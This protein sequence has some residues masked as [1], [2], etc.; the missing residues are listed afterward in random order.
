MASV[1]GQRAPAPFA[2]TGGPLT[3]PESPRDLC[4]YYSPRGAHAGSCS[5]PAGPAK[6]RSGACEDTG[7]A[8]RGEPHQGSARPR[9]PNRLPSHPPPPLD[10][11]P[12]TLGHIWDRRLLPSRLSVLSGSSRCHDGPGGSFP[13]QGSRRLPGSGTSRSTPSSQA[14]APPPTHA[15]ASCQQLPG[16]GFG[17]AHT[18][19]CHWVWGDVRLCSPAH[20][21]LPAPPPPRAPTPRLGDRATHGSE[22]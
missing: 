19:P 5:G 8:A 3:C 22:S 11:V 18:A 10:A 2:W 17:A 7:D 20:L 4:R 21:P 13:F 12:P 1:T 16:G 15:C 6:Q 9:R 14:S